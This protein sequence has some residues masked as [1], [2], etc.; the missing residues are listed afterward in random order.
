MLFIFYRLEF[1]PMSENTSHEF[2][3]LN[4]IYGGGNSYLGE[5]NP[6]RVAGTIEEEIHFAEYV[7]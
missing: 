3:R 2:N 1:N 7:G 6:C 4:Q 5:K